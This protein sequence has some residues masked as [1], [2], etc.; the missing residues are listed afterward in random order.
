MGLSV[1]SLSR[2]PLGWEGLERDYYRYVWIMDGN[3]PLGDAGRPLALVSH[4]T[5]VLPPPE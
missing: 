4:A 2:L 5:S 3:E 1:H